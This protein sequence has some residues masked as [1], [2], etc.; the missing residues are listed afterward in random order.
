MNEDDLARIE[1][2]ECSK[3]RSRRFEEESIERPEVRGLANLRPLHFYSVEIG[4]TVTAVP[5]V[6]DMTPR[7]TLLA[8]PVA[9]ILAIPLVA[10]A[11]RSPPIPEQ[12][13][14]L[15]ISDIDDT[16]KL[17][18]V[19]HAGDAVRRGIWGEKAFA[20]MPELYQIMVRDPAS[21]IFLSG[22][23]KL[24]THHVREVLDENGFPPY[25]LLMR[26]IF[27]KGNSVPVHKRARLEEL[28]TANPNRA[29]ILLGD[30][31][32]K[33]PETLTDFANAH[34]G[35][36][37]AIYIHRVLARTIP[38][39]VISFNTAFEIA[40]SELKFGRMTADEAA[41]VGT[42]LL[43]ANPKLVFPSF[44]ECPATITYP[45]SPE[46]EH[47]AVL[48]DLIA[49]NQARWSTYCA[50]RG[51]DDDDDDQNP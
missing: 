19:P 50:N 10:S 43:T 1:T 39:G 38:S 41:K 23:T 12:N 29:F 17:S 25:Q 33:D 30:D 40:L 8:L 49:K 42:V 20:G 45:T 28:A 7:Q 9:L 6:K 14:P 11:T 13:S 47:S 37:P 46:T 22:G 18:D 5:G 15:I 51:T 3:S 2:S 26:N 32:E 4:V 36:V 21:M 24:L 44:V 34:P 16:V 27:K 31:G 48:T 35:K